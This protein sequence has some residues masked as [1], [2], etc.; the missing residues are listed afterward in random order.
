MCVE[1]LLRAPLGN[2]SM[3]SVNRC[4]LSPLPLLPGRR[5]FGLFLGLFP[6]TCSHAASLL[7]MRVFTRGLR[8]A[9]VTPSDGDMPMAT[10]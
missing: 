4:L 6:F 3:P 8:A 2:H 10:S 1:L 5:R 9:T 7:G